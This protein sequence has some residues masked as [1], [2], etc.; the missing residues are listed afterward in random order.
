MTFSI[1]LQQKIEQAKAQATKIRLGQ[2]EL[3]NPLLFAPM[4]G[5]SNRSYRRLMEEV[6]AGGT[7]SELISA[8][9]IRFKNQKTLDM[10]RLAQEEKSVGL[11]LFGAD[12]E[13]LA[14]AAA[15]AEEYGPKFIDL[16]L[17]CPVRKVVGSGAGSALMQEAKKLAPL[18]ASVKKS[19]SIPLTIKI[20]TGWDAESRNADEIIKIAYNEGVEWV[21]IHGRTR[22]QKYQGSADWNYLEKLTPAP[23]PLIGN[24]DLHSAR[25]VR[26]RQKQTTLDAL[27]IARGALRFP[28]IFLE[29]LMPSLQFSPS[30]YQELLLKLLD[31]F[32]Q[33]FSNPRVQLLQ[34]R[35]HTVWF[36]AGYP[37][38]AQFRSAVFRCN[39]LPELRKL[40]NQYFSEL[41]TLGARKQLD[42]ESSFLSSG[43]G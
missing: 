19:I 41:S 23:L 9:A 28:F 20:R 3:A 33:D 26:A 21:A 39:S 1:S 30:D 13:D 6:G 15:V 38:S 43:H 7:I 18:F 5:I 22:A 35:K 2:I 11:Q 29:S 25:L 10:L 42:L 27:M 17:G 12:K 16:N 31:Y 40:I 36:A 4:A 14:Y 8:K 32:C 24:G 37:H 34:A